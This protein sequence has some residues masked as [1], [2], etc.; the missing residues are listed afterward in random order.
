MLIEE[1]S[2]RDRLNYTAKAPELTMIQSKTSPKT[3]KNQVTSQSDLARARTVKRGFN[4][5]EIDQ[6]NF[7]QKSSLVDDGSAR[8]DE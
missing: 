8:T 1:P 3:L 7:V 4:V 6:L 5:Q 2:G